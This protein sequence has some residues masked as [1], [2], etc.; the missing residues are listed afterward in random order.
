MSL[1][2]IRV[3]RRPIKTDSGHMV[4]LFCHWVPGVLSISSPFRTSTSKLVSIYAEIE[5]LYIYIY[6]YYLWLCILIYI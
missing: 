4:V 1:D 3:S 5:K 2:K 6:I